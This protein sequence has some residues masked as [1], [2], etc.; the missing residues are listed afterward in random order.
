MNHSQF[1]WKLVD[2]FV[3]RFN[4]YRVYVCIP[5]GMICVNEFIIR[6]YGQGGDWINFGLSYYV[7]IDRNSENGCEIQ[8]SCCGVSVIMLRLKVVKQDTYYSY[9]DADED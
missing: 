9:I 8:D 4:D 3:R 1:R 5:S 6:W 2:G 7:V